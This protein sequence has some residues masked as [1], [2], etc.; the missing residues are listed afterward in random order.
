MKNHT[1]KYMIFIYKTPP[2]SVCVCVCAFVCV[3]LLLLKGQNKFKSTP[4]DK[5]YLN[6]LTTQF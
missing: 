2:L 6:Y 3:L 5:Q 1:Y 4:R